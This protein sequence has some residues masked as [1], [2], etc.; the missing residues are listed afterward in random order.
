VRET[1]SASN[2]GDARRA[3]AIRRPSA[4]QVRAW[5]SHLTSEETERVRRG[6][7]PLWRRF[8]EDGEW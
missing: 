1:S 5:T 2:P 6:T 7:D 3:D 4:A 8:Y